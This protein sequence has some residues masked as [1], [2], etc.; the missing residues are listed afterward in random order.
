MNPY[1]NNNL[2]H[3]REKLRRFFI[4][5]AA[6]TIPTSIIKCIL[7]FLLWWNRQESNSSEAQEDQEMRKSLTKDT[8]IP[9]GPGQSVVSAIAKID[10]QIQ[11]HELD[12]KK[13]WIELKEEIRQKTNEQNN[14][15][16]NVHQ[17][18]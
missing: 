1:S 2:F 15:N 9:D 7:Q 17:N 11:T 16:N 18:H 12:G 6:I 8:D 4:A 10:N 3:F 5:L 14:G 13:P